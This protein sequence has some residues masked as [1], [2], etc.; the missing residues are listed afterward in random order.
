MYGE[1]PLGPPIQAEF[2]GLSPHVRGNQLQMRLAGITRRSIP[3]CTGKP[4]RGV[5][6]SVTHG[7][8]PRMYGET[9]VTGLLSQRLLGLSPH[10]RGNLGLPLPV[11]SGMRSIPACTG[12][13]APARSHRRE[14]WVYPRMYG[15]PAPPRGCATTPMVY[16]RMYGETAGNLPVASR[17]SGLSPHVRGNPVVESTGIAKFRSIPACTGK[18]GS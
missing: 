12:K 11:G 6:V 2:Q 14:H 7:V 8:Y 17:V 16:P 13:P 9:V 3:A 5:S 15:E 1:T 4:Q 10:V 18:P